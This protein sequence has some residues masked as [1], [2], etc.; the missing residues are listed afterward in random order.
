MG[1]VQAKYTREYFTGQ[2]ALGDRTDYGALGADEWRTGGIFHE[3]REPIDLID[4]RGGRVL[5]IGYGR[6]EAA[7]Y[8]FQEKGIAEYVG[9]DFS[10]V[11]HELT[12]ETLSGIES[13]K[14]SV[15]VADALEFMRVEKFSALFDAAF[16]L[17]TIEHIP[18]SEVAEI[19][20]LVLRALRIGGY[21]VVDTPFY[22][23]DED[24]IDQGHTYIDPSAS[25]L[26]P[27][28]KGMHCNK[29]TRKRLLREIGSA[30]FRI[31]GDKKFQRPAL[32][33]LERSKNWIAAYVR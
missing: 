33:L 5:E 8:M 19:L 21:F 6:G 14:W 22:R 25:D 17:D 31:L 29:Y 7:R 4:L 1:F 11:A 9:V 27:C 32:H 12:R 20:P 15:E 13:K 24:Y 18:R 2:T 26:H 3:I 10:E 16:M 28:T 30:G 23:V